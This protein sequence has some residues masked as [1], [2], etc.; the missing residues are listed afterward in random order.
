MIVKTYECY[1]NLLRYD[2]F[3]VDWLDD[4]VALYCASGGIEEGVRRTP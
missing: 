3:W 2:R 1:V 4:S